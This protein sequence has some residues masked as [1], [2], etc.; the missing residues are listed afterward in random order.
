[1][2]SKQK[3]LFIINPASGSSLQRKESISRI[4]GAHINRDIFDPEII[5]SNSPDH[6]LELS[7]SAVQNNTN[8]VVAVG[9]DGSVNLA[10]RPLIGTDVFFGIIPVGSG[11]GLANHLGIPINVYK[12][13]E[14]INR[15]K[16]ILMDS[17]NIND[18]VFFS[19]AGAG[20]DA[21]VAKEYAR[22]EMRG[23]LPYFR[24]VTENYPLY[25]PKKYILNIDGNTITRRALFVVFAN[26]GQFGYNA[27][28][29]PNAQID[30]GMIDVCIARKVPL[31]KAPLAVHQLFNNTIDQSAYIE[32]IKA[33]QVVVKRK[34]NRR[35]N[36]DGESAKLSKKLTIKVNPKS[37]RII[38]PGTHQN[39]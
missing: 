22:S 11:N 30:D 21:L 31:L 5:Q 8:V 18:R 14:I 23:F 33:K 37:L 39:N 3:I 19:I 13:V 26:A 34:K 24:I 10:A 16:F 20:F 9:G 1:M 7:S 32:I 35:I 25:K 6:V 28:I 4:I 29:A 2:I 36:L 12:A 38:V 27:I 15:R 17:V